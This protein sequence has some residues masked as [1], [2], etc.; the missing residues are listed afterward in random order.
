MNK[1]L[2]SIVAV[3]LLTL[4][5][6]TTAFALSATQ[7]TPRALGGGCGNGYSRQCYSLMIDADGNLVSRDVFESN[8]DKAI[9]DGLFS[10]DDKEYFLG[11]YDYC[12]ENGG[13]MGGGRG[14]GGRG[15]FARGF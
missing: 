7:T 6:A 3:V 13:V 14:C 15:G 5:M 4:S 12:A 1:K 9:T 8:L 10:A 2:M 11:M